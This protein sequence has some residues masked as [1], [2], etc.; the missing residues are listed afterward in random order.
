MKSE[1]DKVQDAETADDWDEI[2]ACEYCDQAFTNSNDL[3]EHRETHPELN[4]EHSNVE[5]SS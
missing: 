5:D 2:Y 1:A 3:L 4:E